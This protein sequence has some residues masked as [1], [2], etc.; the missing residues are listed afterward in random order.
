MTSRGGLSKWRTVVSR[1][2]YVTIA[3][4]MLC[5]CAKVGTDAG[6]TATAEL[7]PRSGSNVHGTVRFSQA[8]E[9]VR[10][11]G[12]LTGGTPGMKGFHIHEKGDCSA[13]DAMSAAGHY[14]PA[15]TKH[16]APG[17]GHAGDLGN[18]TFDAAGNAHIDKT[19][20]GIAVSREPARG[21]VGRAVIVHLQEDDLKTDPTG[22]A[23]GRAACGVIR[24]N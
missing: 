13:P 16:G 2:L 23:G 4:A 21:I 8:G 1:K 22:N 3:L 9:R 17:A 14:N 12:E 20:S 10:I 7:Q 15:K 18:V 24:E 19:V 11:T 6:P 5:G